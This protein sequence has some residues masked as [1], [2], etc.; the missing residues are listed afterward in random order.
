MA[1]EPASLTE[2]E[3]SGLA[4]APCKRGPLS[5]NVSVRF[6]VVP[7]IFLALLTACGTGRHPDATTAVDS[8]PSPQERA[9]VFED[10]WRTINDQYYDP[11]FHGVNW[12]EAHH[13]YRLSLDAVKDDTE[14]YAP[15]RNAYGG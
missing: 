8:S 2:H 3:A 1:L 11:S 6:A 10:V 12:L 4:R 9:E 5:A 15:G 14:L 7:L 13:R